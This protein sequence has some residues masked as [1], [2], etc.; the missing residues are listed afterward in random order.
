[1]GLHDRDYYKEH[2][3]KLEKESKQSIPPTKPTLK[4]NSSGIDW[5]ADSPTIWPTV[6]PFL[7]PFILLTIVLI[8]LVRSIPTATVQAQPRPINI[9]QE[10]PKSTWKKTVICDKEGNNCKTTYSN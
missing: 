1:M 4:P 7:W 5:P 6:W 3:Q 10:K 9:A 8:V 2:V